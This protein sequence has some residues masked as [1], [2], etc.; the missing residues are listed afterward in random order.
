MN[1]KLG[2]ISRLLSHILRHDSRNNFDERGFM[3]V[4]ELFLNYSLLPL[5]NDEIE[6]IVRCDGKKRFDLNIIDG[7][8]FIRANQGHSKKVGYLLNDNLMYEEI[9]VPM[10]FCLHGTNHKNLMSILENGLHTMNRK[11]IH[12]IGGT[13]T[14]LR[15]EQI[16]GFRN[17]STIIIC[18][19]MKKCLEANMKFYISSNGVI[20]TQG[21][22]ERI[23][24]SFFTSVQII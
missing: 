12:F 9:R 13:P 22:N 11:H 16:S 4:S 17:D 19:D 10:K 7:D 15:C 3:K 21:I 23:D 18:I 8:Y 6:T 24:P 2:K 20:L 14:S 5:I 1:E